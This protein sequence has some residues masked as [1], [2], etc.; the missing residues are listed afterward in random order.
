MASE[1]IPGDGSNIYAYVGYRSKSGKII[2]EWTG[3]KL[4]QYPDDFGVFSSASNEAPD[5]VLIQGEYYL[6]E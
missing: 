5:D 1:I 2:N 4:S 3:R 6:T